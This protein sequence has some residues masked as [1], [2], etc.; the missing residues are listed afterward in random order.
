MTFFKG[1]FGMIRYPTH[2]S[3][4]GEQRGRDQIHPEL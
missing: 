4:E 2:D 1:H 3:N